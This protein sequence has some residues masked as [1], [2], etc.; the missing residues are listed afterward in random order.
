ML[1]NVVDP[2]RAW[3]KFGTKP[4]VVIRENTLGIWNM[5]VG[6]RGCSARV[7]SRLAIV[8][9]PALCCSALVTLSGSGWRLLRLVGP[10]ALVAAI[11][12]LVSTTV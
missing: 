4:N 5:L 8:I 1:G 7:G 10:L 9:E 12:L 11:A 3:K 2:A 6:W